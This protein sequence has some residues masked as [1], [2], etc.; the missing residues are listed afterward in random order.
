M[1][2]N[3]LETITVKIMTLTSQKGKNEIGCFNQNGLLDM[4]FK[5]QINEQLCLLV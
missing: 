2:Q 3:L 5:F 4:G 1:S